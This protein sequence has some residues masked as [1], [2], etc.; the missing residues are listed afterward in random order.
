MT[1]GHLV[2]D[3]LQSTGLRLALFGLLLGGVSY[4]TTRPGFRRS[5]GAYGRGQDRVVRA[6]AIPLLVVG[7]IGL[8]LWV[9]GA[10]R[11]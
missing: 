10:L 7:V 2:A 8:V 4:F 5:R 9:V 11:G 1:A 3:S 6:V